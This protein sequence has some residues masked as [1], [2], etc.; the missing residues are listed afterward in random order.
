MCGFSSPVVVVGL[1]L[2]MSLHPLPPSSPPTLIIHYPRHHS[3][4]GTKREVDLV[5]RG[6]FSPSLGVCV[7]PSLIWLSL[8]RPLP[9][10]AHTHVYYMYAPSCEAREMNHEPKKEGRTQRA[11]PIF[12]EPPAAATPP[13]PHIHA[14]TPKQGTGATSVCRNYFSF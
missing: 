11:R 1:S 3:H 12:T 10:H 2:D 7:T 14:R 8:S 9:M 6:H 5:F 13:P 4:D